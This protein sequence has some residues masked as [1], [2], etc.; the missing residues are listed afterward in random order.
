M[1]IN[2][3]APVYCRNFENLE[4]IKK[5]VDRSAHQRRRGAHFGALGRGA[6]SV[7]MYI[8]TY[9]AVCGRTI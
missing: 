1:F 4:R 9:V 3:I 6:F 8:C 5:R 7:L 2:Q